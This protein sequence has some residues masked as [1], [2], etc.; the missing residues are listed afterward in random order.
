MGIQTDKLGKPVLEDWDDPSLKFENVI[1]PNCSSS[2]AYSKKSK[3]D[4]NTDLPGSMELIDILLN[5]Y[6]CNYRSHNIDKSLL[7]FPYLFLRPADGDKIRNRTTG[8]IY[9]VVETVLNPRNKNWEGL[10]KLSYSS[11][12]PDRNKVHKL[13]FLNEKNYVRF[14]SEDPKNLGVESQD[15]EGLLIDKGPIRPTVVHSL[16]RKMPGTI[17]SR[18]FAPAKQYRPDLVET[19]RSADDPNHTVEIYMQRFDNLVQFDCWTTDNFSADKL[20][21]WFEKFMSLYG[22]VLKLNGVQEVLFWERLR[23]AS[24]TKWRQDLKSRAVQYF[25]RTESLEAVFT[26]DITDV[27]I[28]VSLAD[29]ISPC[30]G[31]YEVAGQTVSGQLTPEEYNSMFRDTDGKYLFGDFHVTDQNLT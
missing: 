24:V 18:P 13:E 3:R 26:R 2:A 20:A 27:D 5:Q 16:I 22:R 30:V 29:S 10:V 4:R 25:M 9:T 7:C 11:T 23:D 17:G 15:E 19:M 8:E 12:Y 14:T 31:I 1:I 28:S 21:D 6:E